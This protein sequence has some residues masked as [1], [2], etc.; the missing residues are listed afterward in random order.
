MLWY[1]TSNIRWL[2]TN[3]MLKI[4]QKSIA[5]E[6]GNAT[7]TFTREARTGDDTLER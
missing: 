3:T 5:E 4:T 6:D 2:G 7:L 1:I